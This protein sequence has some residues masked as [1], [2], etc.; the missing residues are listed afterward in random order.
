MFKHNKK[1]LKESL[2]HSDLLE[3]FK[4]FMMKN[5]MLSALMVG[6]GGGIKQ[7]IFG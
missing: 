3:P 7:D 5:L 4:V 1:G 6:G 2:N